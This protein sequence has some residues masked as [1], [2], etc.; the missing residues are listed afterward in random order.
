MRNPIKAVK[1]LIEEKV[2]EFKSKK[3]ELLKLK[4]WQ[5]K[6][7]NARSKI[8]TEAFDKRE[9][10]YL[11]TY[12]V[13][14]NQNN[15]NQPTKKANNV[16][17]I[18]YEFTETMIDTTIPQPSVISRRYGFEDQ[19]KM[20]EDSIKNDLLHIGI[21]KI[22][23]KNERTTQIQGYSLVL[24]EWNPESDSHIFK[25]DISLRE[26]HPKQFL[27][28]PGVYEIDEMDYFFI[29]NSVT[30]HYIK[31]RYG[32]DLDAE[33][34]EFAQLNEI[35]GAT[36]INQNRSSNEKVTEI[37]IFYKDDEGEVGKYVYCNNVVLEDIPKFY[38]RKLHK[39]SKCNKFEGECECKKPKF[40]EEDLENE[41][42]DH[43][44]QI[45]NGEVIP[46]GEKIPY[47]TPKIYPVAMRINVPRN[48]A[49]GGMSDIDVVKDQQDAI[50][51]MTTAVEEK[52]IRGGTIITAPDTMP[53]TLTNQLYQIVKGTP[54]EL[55][56]FSV[57][58]LQASVTQELEAIRFMYQSARDTLGITEAFQG[59][60]DNTA[61]S[62][63]AKMINIQQSAGRLN[64][65]LFNKNIFF[66]RLFEIIALFKLS[67]IDEK[68]PYTYKDENGHEQYGEFIKYS[69]LD[70]DSA[71]E[72]YYNVAFNITADAGAGLPKDKMW[73]LDMYL[74]LFKMQILT[75]LQLLRTLS[76]LQLNGAHEIY[77]QLENQA[78]ALEQ[79][80]VPGQVPPGAM[81]GQVQPE[82]MPQPG[83]MPQP[84]PQQQIPPEAMQ[85]DQ[86]Q[87]QGTPTL[88]EAH[89]LVMDYLQKNMSE[90]EQ[91]ELANA[92]KDVQKRVVDEVL[93]ELGLPPLEE[94]QGGNNINGQ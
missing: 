52:I 63:K 76:D 79:G 2:D 58:N 28:Q 78:Q 55:A 20:L 22:N 23:D 71:G 61:T 34:D 74:N 44:V 42:L 5:D 26:I 16:I 51:K 49:F 18:H 29:L 92:P 12:D 13:E 4:E 91:Q 50:K 62:G 6:F 77:K 19:A 43:D 15:P 33:Q 56:N 36:N 31:S 21:D 87:G 80:Q 66:T 40:N 69:L 57:R 70:R 17:N 59:K 85:G 88:D 83:A 93:K 27:P 47:F 54:Q 37:I 14:K 68:R 64:S 1:N 53:V 89:A 73:L 48:F 3:E 82:A 25:G 32:K 38:H 81:P 39:C 90:S 72:L 60:P 94:L 75:P 41:V 8:D 45:G 35:N 7:A 9:R 65:K 67:F 86:P 30:K 24:V 10:L 11:G 84:Q 46:A